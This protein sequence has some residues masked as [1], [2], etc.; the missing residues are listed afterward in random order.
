MGKKT[1]LQ[2]QMWPEFRLW[3]R[4][5]KPSGSPNERYLHHLPFTQ[6]LLFNI[7]SRF[8]F[9]VA[10]VLESYL[11]F[12]NSVSFI[13][14][15]VHRTWGQGRADLLCPIS[16]AQ[17]PN[18]HRRNQRQESG[19]IRSRTRISKRLR[20]GTSLRRLESPLYQPPHSRLVLP[21][22]DNLIT[23]YWLLVW[24]IHSPLPLQWPAS[25]RFPARS[26]SV[27]VHLPPL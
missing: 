15:R 25:L 20:Y 13:G 2:V 18:L 5:E 4:N 19:S 10:Y 6:C 22:S 21:I 24:P 12:S 9:L 23:P 26:S 1:E 27:S 14:Q 16:T 11:S 3:E 7:F 8:P 17:P